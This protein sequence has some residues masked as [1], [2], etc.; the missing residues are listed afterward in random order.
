MNNKNLGGAYDMSN[1]TITCEKKY[2]S[3][4]IVFRASKNKLFG[5]KE[6]VLLK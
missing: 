6:P 1:I 4:T 2:A 3:A 5:A